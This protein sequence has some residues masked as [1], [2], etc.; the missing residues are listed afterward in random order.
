MARRVPQQ[1]RGRRAAAMHAPWRPPLRRRQ[2]PVDRTAA[3]A[4]VLLACGRGR[5]HG[6]RHIRRSGLELLHR[7]LCRY[8][9]G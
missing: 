4:D 5:W 8:E 1:G 6:R 2:L 9:G 7:L 3:G